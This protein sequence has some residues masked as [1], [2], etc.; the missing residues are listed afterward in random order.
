MRKSLISEIVVSITMFVIG[1]FLLLFGQ[2]LMDMIVIILGVSLLLYGAFNIFT[3]FRYRLTNNPVSNLVYGIISGV[4]GVILVFNPE[5]IS[6]IIS[7]IVGVY[8]LFISIPSLVD[9]IKNKDKI[10]TISIGLSIAGI[11]IGILC[12]IG[13]LVI[14]SIV[15]QFLGLMLIIYSIINLINVILI[16]QGLDSKKIKVID[17]KN[18][19]VE[20]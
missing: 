17:N 1:L 16:N 4:F 2:T 6:N 3:Y 20:K 19:I 5:I 13:K 15:F 14:P 9:A 8:I 7:F 12:L 18:D 11:V 10:N